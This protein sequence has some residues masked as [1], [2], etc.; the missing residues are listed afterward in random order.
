MKL[1]NSSA[2]F[3][4]F[5]AT[6]LLAGNC[7]TFPVC[8][9]S[10]PAS[11]VT[12]PPAT[13]G[14]P[15]E[16]LFTTPTAA[17]LAAILL[18]GTCGVFPVCAQPSHA[19]L[20]QYG[21]PAA[22]TPPASSQPSEELFVSPDQAIQALRAATEA[23]DKTA[24]RD[25][26]GRQ[27]FDLMTGDDVLDANNAKHFA[28]A[29]AQG[30][31]PV[32][33]SEDSITL[34][35]GTNNWPLPVP[36]VRTSG[37]WHFDTS[38]GREEIINRHIG[39][40]ELHAIGVCRA[41]V[42]AQR[43]FASMNPDSAYALKFKSSEGKKD[44]LYWPTAENETAS[45]FGPLVA[46]AHVQG[47]VWHKDSEAQAYHGYYFRIL[48]RQGLA[49][50]GGAKDYQTHGQLTKGFALVAYPERWDQ[51]GIMTFIVNQD[52]KVWQRNL[53]EGT[54]KLAA[55]LQEYNPDSDW[56]LVEDDGVREAV[57]KQ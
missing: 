11:S 34:E 23:G 41:Y 37:Q 31:R 26:F 3:S 20:L 49:A 6:V 13:L 43:Q 54:V 15:S 29:M 10:V 30:C 4:P 28:V 48:T 45:P 56:M 53:G 33:N 44:G 47:Y 39:K 22:T 35:V 51:S 55:A 57:L 32:T 5:L 38:A 19:G 2:S 27:V 17:I 52:G 1:F 9:Q 25:L 36:L 50:D 7:D 18:A 24:L 8:A 14:R 16:K 42:T 40:D 46:K 12:R 21:S